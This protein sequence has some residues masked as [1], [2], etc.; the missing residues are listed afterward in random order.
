MFARRIV[1]ILLVAGAVHMMMHHNHFGHEESSAGLPGDG[2]ARKPQFGHGPF[3]QRGDWVKRTEWANHVPP[4]FEM[5]H[6]RAHA[7]QSG[8]TAT[9]NPPASATPAV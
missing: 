7:A 6:K 4:M 1:P 8:E 5:W 9:Q 2:V 3:A